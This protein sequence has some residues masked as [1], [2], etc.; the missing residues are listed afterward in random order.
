M[1]KLRSLEYFRSGAFFQNRRHKGRE[2][3]EK[4]YDLLIFRKR[5]ITSAK[6]C[7]YFSFEMS[8]LL[9]RLVNS[10]QASQPFDLIISGNIPQVCQLQ[11]EAENFSSFCCDLSLLSPSYKQSTPPVSLS[12]REKPRK[13]KST[14]WASLPLFS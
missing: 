6:S 2:S 1:A 7:R 12:A 8:W 11:N 5:F 13:T 4:C 9:F 14:S 3:C 10:V